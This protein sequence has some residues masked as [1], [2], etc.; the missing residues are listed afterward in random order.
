MENGAKW[1]AEA[2]A[3]GG[4]VI[5]SGAG[6][7]TESGLKDFRSKDGLWSQFDPTR[8]ASVDML[9]ENYDAF[10]EFY[11]ARL[12][13]PGSVKPNRGHELIAEWESKGWIDGVITQNVDR[14]H[15]RAGS[16]KVAELHGSLEPVRCHSCGKNHGK[17][18]FIDGESC[19][20]CGGRLRPGVVLFGEMLPS[21]P[22]G[23][24]DKW[25]NECR[26]FIV[27]GSSLT[28]SPANFFPRQAK[29][30]G[31]KL[32]IINRDETPL[33]DMA[34]LSVHEGIG[35]YLE[36]VSSYMPDGQAC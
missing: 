31:A 25:S 28:V 35:G 1:L 10:R 27:L 8:L 2:I 22:L 11:I 15:Q 19:S 6:M 26:L 17:E 13:V 20:A 36:N 16:V 18:A 33:D 23:L 3:A 5:F 34:D 14:L 30:N 7:S 21:E 29:N 9:E 32:V 24:A 12:L 4:A